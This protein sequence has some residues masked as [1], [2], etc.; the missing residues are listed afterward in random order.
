M[1]ISYEI[2]KISIFYSK[3]LKINNF[4]PIC[5]EFLG[6]SG[7]I[8]KNTAV[9][10]IPGFRGLSNQE[11]RGHQD[12][13][14]PRAFKSRT[15][16]A[17]RFQGS[18]GFQIKNT[19]GFQIKNTAGFQIK[20]TAGFQIKNTAGF[21]IKNTAGTKIP[22]FRGLYNQEHRGHQDFSL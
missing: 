9:P 19:A 22:G 5:L 14:V 20:N 7:F 17:P 10:Q 18:A 3:K 1:L 4:R 11:H 12:S 21:Q 15:P 16:R 13:M 6:S 8:T 2:K